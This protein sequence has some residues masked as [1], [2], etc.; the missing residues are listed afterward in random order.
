MIYAGIDEA[1]YGPLLGPLCV[2]TSAF[3]LPGDDLRSAPNLWKLLELG[4]CRAP[5]DTRR[6]IAIADSK[7]LK[8]VGGA[9]THPL[10]HLERGVLAFLGGEP[11]ESDAALFDRLG[12]R[13][14][15]SRATPW[16]DRA[17]PAPVAMTA[18]QATI[19]RNLAARALER[20]EASCARLSVAALDA[21]A[22]NALYGSLQNKARVNL[23]LVLDALRS[24]DTI[25]GDEPALVAI[26]RQ[27]GRAEYAQLLEDHVARGE[28]V[29]TIEE[30]D[31]RSAYEVGHGLVVSFEVE[32]ESSHLPVALASMAAKYT[33]ELF[34]RRLNAYFAERRP[35]LAPTAGYVTDGRR[36]LAEVKPILVEAGIP[37]AE[38]TRCV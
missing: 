5:K 34:M 32:A 3:R 33:R 24:V 1:G 6:R 12:A 2:G 26:D 38:F 14:P 35:G 17:M 18:D 10:A 15:R 9:A 13:P 4:V 16:H 8:G 11:P 29:R 25:R 28:Q 19:A 21:P 20:A 37:E 7:K 31:T 27:G 23:S 36:Y 22:F 30:T